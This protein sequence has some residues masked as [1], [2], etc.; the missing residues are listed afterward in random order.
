MNLIEEYIELT[1]ICAETDYS[2]KKSVKKHN[3]SVDRMYEIAEKIGYE[4][5][6]ETID[7]FKSLLDIKDNKTNIWA[8]VHMIERIPID[9][10]TENK[11][12]DLIKEIAKGDTAEAMGFRYWLDDY[13]KSKK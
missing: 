7:D 8:A 9:K 4:M 10:K 5:T 11:A 13:K 3:K 2:D 12:I 6:D 1:K